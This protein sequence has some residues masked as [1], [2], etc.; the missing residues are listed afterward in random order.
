MEEGGKGAKV[1]YMG[2]KVRDSKECKILF[3]AE[4]E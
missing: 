1:T 4:Y 3:I 2:E